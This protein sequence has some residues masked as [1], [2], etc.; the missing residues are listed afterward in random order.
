M[1]SAGLVAVLADVAVAAG[2]AE[3]WGAKPG[4]RD[5]A[6]AAG[7]APL[8]AAGVSQVLWSALVLRPGRRPALPDLGLGT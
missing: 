7:A 1:A 8:G 5:V 6:E 4:P 2:V 3:A